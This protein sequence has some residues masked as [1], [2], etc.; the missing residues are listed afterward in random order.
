GLQGIGVLKFVDEDVGETL[1]EIG[2]DLRFLA[3]QIVGAYQQIDEIELAGPGL[4]LGIVAGEILHLG[5]KLGREIGVGALAKIF[6]SQEEALARGEDVLAPNAIGE[7]AGALSRV[8]LEVAAE[9]DQQ[10]LE[11]IVILAARLGAAQPRDEL[12]DRAQCD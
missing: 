10:T 4:E 5:A 12:L 1:L 7:S 2:A 11:R 9:F 8:A 3:Q 6:E